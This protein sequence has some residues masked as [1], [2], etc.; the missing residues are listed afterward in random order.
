MTINIIQTKFKQKININQI[1]YTHSKRKEAAK[2]LGKVAVVA[3]A[4]AAA[5]A[6]ALF[7]KR[8]K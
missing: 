2:M 6:I 7:I 8:N 4:V 3:V 1:K 5:A